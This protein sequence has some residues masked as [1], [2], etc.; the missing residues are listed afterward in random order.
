MRAKIISFNPPIIEP[1]IEKV[2]V[3]SIHAPET[4]AL[5]LSILAARKHAEINSKWVIRYNLIHDS[6]ELREI[7][8]TFDEAFK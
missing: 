4:I 2:I 8:R 6:E 5:H 3:F 1:I 7:C